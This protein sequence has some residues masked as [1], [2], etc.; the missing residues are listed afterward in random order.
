MTTWLFRRRLVWVLG[1]MAGFM[2]ISSMAGTFCVVGTGMPPQ[3]HYD[4]AAS[5]ARAVTGFDSSCTIN[6]ELE[7]MYYGSQPYCAV[8]ADRV[9]QCLY[10]DRGAC[11]RASGNGQSVCI[12][13]RAQ[14]KEID[15]DAN[16]FRYDTRIQD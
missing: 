14:L 16:P 4:D 1:L 12:S 8:T 11:I 10:D 6:P 15:N 9:A 3:C 7:L 2:A 5:C 13:R